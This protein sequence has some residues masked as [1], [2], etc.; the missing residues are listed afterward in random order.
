VDFGPLMPSNAVIDNPSR[1]YTPP[2]TALV[3][4][5]ASID[6]CVLLLIAYFVVRPLHSLAQARE[7]SVVS[8]F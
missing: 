3:W 5:T 4:Q 1:D 8:S 7:G 6:C 2:S